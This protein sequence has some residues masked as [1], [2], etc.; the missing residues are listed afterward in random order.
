[1]R[2]PPTI[3][4]TGNI[5]AQFAGSEAP[6]L[7]LLDSICAWAAGLGYRACRYPSWVSGFIDLEKGRDVENICG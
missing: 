5:L 3:G 6:P 7:I 4:G 1:M 2:P